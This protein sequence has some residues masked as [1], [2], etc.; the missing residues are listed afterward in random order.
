MDARRAAF[1]EMAKAHSDD[2][3][4]GA[5]GGDLGYFARSAMVPEF[6][7]PLFDHLDTLKPGDIVG[8]VKSDFGWHVIMFEGYEPPLADRLGTLKT[9]LAKPDADFAA[10]AKSSSDGAEGPLGGDLGWRAQSQLPVDAS[11]ALLALAPGAVSDPI[12]LDDGYH[13]YKLI[14]KAD[15]PL[16][17]AQVAEISATAFDDWYNPQKDDAETSGVITRDDSITSS[18]TG[19]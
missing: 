15:Q 12:A 14:E 17:P 4:S 6:A 11:A 5:D 7:D 8:P 16:D 1:E 19:G 2:T 9:E 13:V 3:G 18:T 10:I